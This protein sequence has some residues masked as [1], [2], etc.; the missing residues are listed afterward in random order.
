MSTQPDG[1]IPPYVDTSTLSTCGVYAP[2][3]PLMTCADYTDAVASDDKPGLNKTYCLPEDLTFDRSVMT[4][5]LV[6]DFG[7]V[8]H[9]SEWHGPLGATYMLGMMA[10]CFRL[11]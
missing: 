7:L 10:S 8:C 3:D 2:L 11:S 5:S 1:D 9:Q 4:R 6:E